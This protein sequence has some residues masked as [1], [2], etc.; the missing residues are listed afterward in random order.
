MRNR[1]RIRIRP[2]PGLTAF[3]CAKQGVLGNLLDKLWSISHAFDLSV[4]RQ[5][6]GLREGLGFLHKVSQ[7]ANRWGSE[8]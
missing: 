2:P 7:G 5:E 8:W 4:P 1:H 3:T 6:T